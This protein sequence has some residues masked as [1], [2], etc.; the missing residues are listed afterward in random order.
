MDVRMPKMDGL[1][2]TRAIKGELPRVGV[3]MVTTHD[4]PDYLM[5]AVRAGAAGYVLKD[6]TKAEI[7]RAVRGTLS[8]GSTFDAELAAR[9]LRQVAKSGG[10]QPEAAASTT[11]KIGQGRSSGRLR[12]GP[13]EP[14]TKREQGVLDLLVRGR[15]DKEIAAELH[16]SEGTV[17]QRVMGIISKLAVSDRTQAAVRA[18]EL[19]LITS[20]GE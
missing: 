3:L 12:K 1:E 19:G 20:R 4:D 11:T 16:F 5:E 18:M 9:L 15:T 8:G 2:A 6:A 17:K 14:L 13:V 7:V 10:A